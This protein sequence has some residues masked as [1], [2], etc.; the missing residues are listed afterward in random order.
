MSPETM[1][2]ELADAS[3]FRGQAERICLPES[4]AELAA[5]LREASRARTPVTICGAR[6]GLTGGGMPSS[7]W[8]I[9]MDRF[10]RLDVHPGFALCGAG[11]LLS[12][13]QAAAAAGGQLYPPDPTETSASIGGTIVTNASGSRSFLYG[14]TRRYVRALRV[15]LMSGETLVLRRGE[16]APFGLPLLPQPASTKNTAGYFLPADADFLDLFIGS[17]GTLGIVT[18]AELTLLA[19]PKQLCSGVVFFASDDAALAAVDAWRG[20]SG[21]RMLEYLD[22]ASL[23][24]LRARFPEIPREAAAALLIEQ[25]TDGIADPADAAD[26][27]DR[28]LERL[29]AADAL[30]DASWFAMGAADRE[31]FRRFRHALP[32]A[33]NGLLRSRGLMKLASDFAVPVAHNRQMLRLYRET[34]DRRMPGRYVIFGHI[35]DAHLHLNLLPADEAERE[36]AKELLTGFARQ[37]VAFGGTVSAEHGLGKL[38]RHLLPLQFSAAQIEQMKAVKRRLDPGWLLGQ[39]TLFPE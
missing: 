26:P 12:Q 9:S 3:G 18:E 39:G 25:E 38:K 20:V 19:A 4:E 29:E 17:E 36:Q 21:L 16:K 33:V 1:S 30:A 37:A 8:L 11:V 10:R 14:P 24:L 7:G 35:G 34:L 27:E 28:W 13:L 32:E 6:T 2:T 31:R 5:I 22:A 23:A 15:M